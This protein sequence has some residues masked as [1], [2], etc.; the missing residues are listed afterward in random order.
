MFMIWDSRL[1]GLQ[2]FWLNFQHWR[3]S[4]LGGGISASVSMDMYYDNVLS[5]TNWW[6]LYQWTSVLDTFNIPYVFNFNVY[7]Y[8]LVSLESVLL[9]PTMS[10][11]WLI[12]SVPMCIDVTICMLMFSQKI[13]IESMHRIMVPPLQLTQCKLCWFLSQKFMVSITTMLL[14]R[15]LSIFKV[16][17]T[18]FKISAGPRTLTGKFGSVRQAFLLY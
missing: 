4:R 13:G 2:R 10:L 15:R 14:S 11:L 5:R 6:T 3:G 1:E 18:V 12:L 8:I 7:F 9:R 17:L 16:I